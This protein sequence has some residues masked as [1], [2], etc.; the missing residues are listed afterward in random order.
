MS[1]PASPERDRP[2]PLPLC[3]CLSC[4]S[5]AVV[6]YWTIRCVVPR[7]G[8]RMWVQWRCEVFLLPERSHA[9][10]FPSSVVFSDLSFPPAASTCVDAKGI[11]G[12]QNMNANGKV[13]CPPTCITEDGAPQCGGTGCGQLPGRRT[14]CC[15][16]FI[17]DGDDCAVTGEALCFIAPR[18]FNLRVAEKPSVTTFVELFGWVIR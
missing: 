13:C 5:T 8:R 12:I 2:P 11:P 18:E 14:E 17:L 16:N 4:P 6:E 1:P 15:I 3:H 10:S 9:I 7:S